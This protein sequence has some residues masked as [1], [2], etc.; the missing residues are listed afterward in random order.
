[1]D[2]DG[3]GYIDRQEG[4]RQ[5]GPNSGFDT[6]DLNGD[7]RISRE[8]WERIVESRARNSRVLL[9]AISRVRGLQGQ[10]YAV[11][12]WRSKWWA[13]KQQVKQPSDWERMWE[14]VLS[15]IRTFPAL[16]SLISEAVAEP[17]GLHRAV[18]AIVLRGAAQCPHI[19][20]SSGWQVLTVWLGQLHAGCWQIQLSYEEHFNK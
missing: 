19:A 11:W 4:E 12:N 1:M 5:F 13:S 18:S 20:L 15:E 14:A 2:T 8:E 7:G 10:Y 3:S 17:A 16:E 9:A 6:Y